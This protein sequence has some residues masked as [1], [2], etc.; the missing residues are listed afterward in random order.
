MKGPRGR[1]V[2]AGLPRGTATVGSRRRRCCT[3]PRP[4]PIALRGHVAVL[5]GRAVVC[6]GS[7]VCA[8]PPFQKN[9]Q[10]NFPKHSAP[11]PPS[12]VRRW[13]A[14]SHDWPRCWRAA[15]GGRAA[16]TPHRNGCVA[17][18]RVGQGFWYFRGRKI[19]ENHGNRPTLKITEITENHGKSRNQKLKFLLF[20]I[21]VPGCH[22][23][24]RKITETEMKVP[25]VCYCCSWRRWMELVWARTCVRPVSPCFAMV[26]LKNGS[27]NGSRPPP[28]VLCFVSSLVGVQVR[29][30]RCIRSFFVPRRHHRKSRKY[31]GNATEN[32]GKSRKITERHG[33][34]RKITENHGRVFSGQ[35][36]K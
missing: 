28:N 8:G 18:A 14:A 9:F 7:G 29:Q 24:S 34:S 31:H 12:C 21:V 23:K 1:A 3:G 6:H 19:T 30:R 22:E 36:R 17:G 27:P 25:I 13:Q 15:R 10:K 2:R 32:H 4:R 11:P 35:S 26:M 33:K 16:A 5:R 20:A